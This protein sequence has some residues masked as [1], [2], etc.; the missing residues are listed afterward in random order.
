MKRPEELLGKAYEPLFRS[1]NHSHSIVFG[2]YF[3]LSK[4]DMRSR[5]KSILVMTYITVFMDSLNNSF[6]GAILPYMIL[7]MES[8]PFQEGLVFSIYS[9]MQ[10]LSIT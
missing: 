10:L 6:A 3:L 9:L 5:R 8:T 2:Q 7:E 4:M 1:T